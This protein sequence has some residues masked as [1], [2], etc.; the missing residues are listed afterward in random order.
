MLGTIY[1]FS[2]FSTDGI[3]DDGICTIYWLRSD[4]VGIVINPV[5]HITQVPSTHVHDSD[6]WKWRKSF[7][8]F[9][10]NS[11]VGRG[12][13]GGK[14]GAIIATWRGHCGCYGGALIFSTCGYTRHQH[15]R[16]LQG[17]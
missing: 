12:G 17:Q 14:E 3:V 1:Q 16:F 8:I 5:H 7:S 10:I 4:A 2:P 9:T 11:A 15:T 6:R 13:G